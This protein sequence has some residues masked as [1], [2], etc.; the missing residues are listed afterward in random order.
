MLLDSNVVLLKVKRDFCVGVLLLLQMCY[1]HSC[2]N[3]CAEN[4]FCVQATS[5]GA[6]K[7]KESKAQVIFSSCLKKDLLKIYHK[8]KLRFNI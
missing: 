3:I 4:Q 6:A 2:Y 5:V 8:R 1:I 7:N